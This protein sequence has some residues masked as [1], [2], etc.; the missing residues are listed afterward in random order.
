M[1]HF[2]IIGVLKDKFIGKKFKH[3]VN[4]EIIHQPYNVWKKKSNGVTDAQFNSGDLRFRKTVERKKEIG[5]MRTYETSIIV[6]VTISYGHYD[7]GNDIFLKLD[8]GRE[9]YIELDSEV[10]EIEPNTF[11]V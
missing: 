6:D 2:T 5:V 8:N 10:K 9:I 4:Q 7:E 3:C 11:M 1:S